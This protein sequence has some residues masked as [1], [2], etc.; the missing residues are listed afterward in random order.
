MEY[1]GSVRL[2]KAPAASFSGCVGALT[3]PGS[4]WATILQALSARSRRGLGGATPA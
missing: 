3:D 4:E 2:E 1:F